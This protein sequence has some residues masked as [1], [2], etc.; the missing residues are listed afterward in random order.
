MAIS[1]RDIHNDMIKPS[2]N[3]GLESVVDSVT[4]KLL[5][6]NTILRSFISPRVC[7]MT[8]KLRQIFRCELCIIIKD[9]H[10]GLNIFRTILV[11]DLQQKSVGRHTHKSLFSSTS[12]AHYKDKV[13]P[14][15]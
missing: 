1:V 10:I 9:M 4:P 6:S 7:K 5:I 15:V 3:V 12:A 14:D 11:T 8:P 2:D 13:F